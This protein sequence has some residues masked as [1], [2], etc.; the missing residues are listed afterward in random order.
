MFTGMKVV[1]RWN[2]YVFSLCRPVS[3]WFLFAHTS[4]TEAT[5]LF[6]CHWLRKPCGILVGFAVEH[7]KNPHHYWG[8]SFG[9]LAPEAHKVVVVEMKVP[10]SNWIGHFSFPF[11]RRKS[12]Y[13]VKV[14]TIWLHDYWVVLSV[15]RCGYN[16]VTRLGDHFGGG[17]QLHFALRFL[18]TI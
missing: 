9:I 3:I 8:F 18:I 6:P 17:Y 15:I 5:P 14:V 1:K 7:T 2:R 16:L 12:F 13:R 10:S 4:S 11:L